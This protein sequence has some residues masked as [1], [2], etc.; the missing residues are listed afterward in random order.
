MI[1]AGLRAVVGLPEFGE[2][3]CFVFLYAGLVFLGVVEVAF[4]PVH[5]FVGDGVRV[6]AVPH[7]LGFLAPPCGVVPMLGG[8]VIVDVSVREG[9]VPVEVDVLRADALHLLCG[10]VIRVAEMVGLRA[11]FDGVGGEVASRLPGERLVLV[12]V[13]FFDTVLGGW[14]LCSMCS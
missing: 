4:G 13:P 3:R 2:R 5:A 8:L 6:V 11:G 9:R 7:G 10:D 12:P 14:C 1:D